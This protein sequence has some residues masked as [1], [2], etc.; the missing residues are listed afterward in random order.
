[1]LYVSIDRVTSL[2]HAASGSTTAE[3]SETALVER[4]QHGDHAAFAELV[5]TVHFTGGGALP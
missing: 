5:D 2:G 4:A 3:R 1:M